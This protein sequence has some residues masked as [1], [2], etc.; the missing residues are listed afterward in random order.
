LRLEVEASLRGIDGRVTFLG[1]L[2]TDELATTLAACD[3]FVWPAIKEAIGMAFLE[4]QAAGLPVVG[5]DRGGV[6]A[7]V[8]H[9]RTGLLAPEGDAAGLA[10]AIEALL[11]DAGWRRAMGEAAAAYVSSRHDIE[12]EGPRFIAA[13]EEL[14]A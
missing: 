13:L 12:T 14:A 7:V 1:R 10:E 11:D 5:A 9:G 3:L 6:P 4:A 2:E 8:T